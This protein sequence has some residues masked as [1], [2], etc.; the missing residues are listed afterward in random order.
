MKSVPHPLRALTAT[1]LATGLP[2]QDPVLTT[3][4]TATW[5]TFDTPTGSRT[6]FTIFEDTVFDWAHLDLP[7]GSEFYFDFV[8]G[9]SVLNYL[10]GSRGHTIAGQVGGNGNLGFFS[11][12]GDINVTG[13]IVADSV[14]IA[15]LGIDPGDFQDGGGFRMAGPAGWNRL[16]V[17]GSVEATAGDVVLA[18]RDVTVTDTGRITAAGAVM[19]A[20]GTDV[21]VAGTGNRRLS[22][23]S[24]VGF[25]LHLGETRASRIEVA[26]GS[27]I[28]NRGRLGDQ[29]A[30]VFL[31]VSDGGR[32]T[33]DGT[34]IIVPDAVF[35][36]DFDAVGIPVLQKEGDAALAINEGSSRISE[37]RRPN[38][39]RVVRAQSVNYTSTVAASGD[40]GRDST[41]RKKTTVAENRRKSSMM[42]QSSFFKMRGGRSPER[43]RKG[44]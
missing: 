41:Q 18:G 10:S 21:A 3:P 19:M 15:T 12:T 2:A 39:S 14:T 36:G 24:G 13:E 7:D 32:I 30:K 6:E 26:A 23:E 31:G 8:G 40:A 37:L 38:G 25:V 5:E 4:G 27:E 42:S 1:L 17:S 29:G 11:P 33:N 43:R 28:V 16:R 34:G 9:E 22:E 44:H 20:G 35:D